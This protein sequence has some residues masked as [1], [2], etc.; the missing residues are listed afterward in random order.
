MNYGY[1]ATRYE[2]TLGSILEWECHH[3]TLPLYIYIYMYIYI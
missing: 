1:G 2:G 3:M